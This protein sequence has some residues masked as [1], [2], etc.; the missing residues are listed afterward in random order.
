MTNGKKKRSHSQKKK[1]SKERKEGERRTP[2]EREREKKKKVN[3]KCVI[4]DLYIYIYKEKLLVLQFHRFTTEGK[5]REKKKTTPLPSEKKKR[6]RTAD[7]RPVGREENRGMT[8]CLLCAVRKQRLSFASQRPAVVNP[9]TTRTQSSSFCSSYC[10]YTEVSGT[11]IHILSIAKKKKK[12]MNREKR[13]HAKSAKI[14][15]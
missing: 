14:S 1:K 3:Q 12:T 2:K 5:R 13:S 9:S 10:I 15:K 6:K 11:A 7:V 8:L 4:G